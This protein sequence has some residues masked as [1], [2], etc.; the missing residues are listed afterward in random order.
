M[1]WR[2]SYKRPIYLSRQL[3]ALFNMRRR[4]LAI[5]LCVSSY[6]RR[7]LVSNVKSDSSVCY[8]QF[9][10]SKPKNLLILISI[11][12]TSIFSARFNCHDDASRRLFVYSRC[13]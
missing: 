1:A 4:F 8:T 3:F 7:P 5:F 12:K 11:C 2:H 6:R 9:A 13:V 10:T